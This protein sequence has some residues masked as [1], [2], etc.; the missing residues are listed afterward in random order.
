MSSSTRRLARQQKKAQLRETKATP[1]PV[2][3]QV[4]QVDD[5]W[6]AAAVWVI[7]SKRQGEPMKVDLSA[8]RPGKQAAFW[9]ATEALK[10]LDPNLAP[11][12][13]QRAIHSA[14]Q[15]VQSSGQKGVS[16]QMNLRL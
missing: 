15:R 3:M 7:S 5:I 6:F 10:D 2:G 12:D 8:L 11:S 13:Q 1:G 4:R 16:A 14:Q 9:R